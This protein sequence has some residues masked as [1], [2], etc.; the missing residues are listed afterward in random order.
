[1][2]R[3]GQAAE[4]KVSQK[5]AVSKPKNVCRCSTLTGTYCSGNEAN[6]RVNLNKE[7]CACIGGG[8]IN[9]QGPVCM[10]TREYDGS[11]AATA[12]KNE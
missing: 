10:R 9:N 12:K 8:A 5:Q 11:A 1:M 4:K 2:S 3:S 6:V 7:Y